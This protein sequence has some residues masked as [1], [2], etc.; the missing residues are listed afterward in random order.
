MLHGLKLPFDS[1]QLGTLQ[2]PESEGYRGAR[3]LKVVFHIMD[4]SGQ[5]LAS[6]DYIRKVFE[7]ARHKLMLALL[8][9][10]PRMLYKTRELFYMW[11]P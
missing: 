4:C 2:P 9:W 1:L 7:E 3:S 10:P 6:V 11:K 5:H 8:V